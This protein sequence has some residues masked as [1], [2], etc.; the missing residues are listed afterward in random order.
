MNK[1]DTLELNKTEC[2]FY[3]IAFYFILFCLSKLEKLA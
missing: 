2:L 3:F 1:L